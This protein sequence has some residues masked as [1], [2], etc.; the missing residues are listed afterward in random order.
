MLQNLKTILLK[1]TETETILKLMKFPNV[2]PCFVKKRDSEIECFIKLWEAFKIDSILGN[3]CEIS[4][5]IKSS[6]PQ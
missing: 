6:V 3:L 4:A 2:E 5:G 1:P